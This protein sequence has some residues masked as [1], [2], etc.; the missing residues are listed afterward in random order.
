M[1]YHE[2]TYLNELEEKAVSRFH[3]TSKQAAAIAKKAEAKKLIIGH[4]SSM[5]DSLEKFKEE[6]CEVFENTELAEEGVCYLV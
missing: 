1:M 4:F 6:A 2:A 3:S 5:Y